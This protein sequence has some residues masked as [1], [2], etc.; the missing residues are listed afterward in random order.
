MTDF[1]A[2]I[3]PAMDDGSADAQES[4][5]ML[6]ML[7]E[8]GVNLVVATPHYYCGMETVESFMKRRER[9]YGM[10]GDTIAHGAAALPQIVLG[11]EVAYFSGM[12]REPGVRALCMGGSDKLL[13][14]MPFNAWGDAAINEVYNLMAMQNVVPI[15]AHA[16]RYMDIGGNR[17]GLEEL[18]ALGVIVQGNAEFF[19]SRRTRRRAMAMLGRGCMHVFGSDC[20]NLAYR[21]PNMGEL[22]RILKKRHGDGFVDSLAEQGR[23]MLS[24][25]H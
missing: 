25:R 16:E 6:E 19:I 4:R 17:D 1:H 5:K 10:L 8:Q 3:L 14:E 18:I 13:L 7:R 2:H 11:A 15:I 12:A 20:H 23:K 21:P 24:S 9:S 22:L